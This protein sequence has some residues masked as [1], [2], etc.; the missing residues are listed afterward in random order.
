ML[1]GKPITR[2]DH[3]AHRQEIAEFASMIDDGPVRFSAFSY[4]DWLDGWPD[5]KALSRHRQSVMEAFKP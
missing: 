2:S 4:R 1:A 3:A 5:S